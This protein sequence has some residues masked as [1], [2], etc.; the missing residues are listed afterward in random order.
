MSNTR[1]EQAGSIQ[2]TQT[3]ELRYGTPW[4]EYF[5]GVCLWALVVYGWYRAASFATSAD[6]VNSV[7]STVGTVAV[8]S[9]LV[10]L[11]IWSRVK[12]VGRRSSR[13]GLIPVP[14]VMHQGVN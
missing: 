10:A 1:S 3:R 8:N 2:K 6:I 11:W 5:M 9:A 4:V 7:W 13:N 14:C 12:S